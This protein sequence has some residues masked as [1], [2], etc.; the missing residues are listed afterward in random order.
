MSTTNVLQFKNVT[1]KYSDSERGEEYLALSNVS[2][3]L[4]EGALAALVGPSGSGKTTLLNLAG[5][6][7]LPTSGEIIL[8]G[9]SINSLSKKELIK[10]RS[11]DIGFIFQAF[12]LIPVL[13]AVENVEY[14]CLMRG[15]PAQEARRKAIQALKDVDLESKTNSLP[16]HLSGGQ[17]QRVAVA[18]ALCSAPK[19]IF[20]DEPTANLDSKTADQLI[21]LFKHLNEKKGVTFLFST[22]DNRLI[23]SVRKIINLRDGKIQNSEN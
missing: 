17:Q 11:F 1:K 19:I 3:D 16:R 20:A 10:C 21:S 23:S 22:H 4:E 13:T 7:D 5:T 18:R 9:K 12:N 8:A 2:F 15:E 14:T 6:F